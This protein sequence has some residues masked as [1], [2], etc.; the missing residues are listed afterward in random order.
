MVDDFGVDH[1]YA[2]RIDA[3]LTNWS[4][5]DV[6]APGVI[7]W[8]TDG[9][10]IT[11]EGAALAPAGPMLVE[12]RSE[13]VVVVTQTCDLRRSCWRPD[14]KGRPFVQISPLVR[15]AGQEL[16]IARGGFH[17]RFAPVPGAGDDAFADLERCTTIEKGVLVK[18]PNRLVGCRDDAERQ[19]FSR[20]VARQR[21]RYAFPDCVDRAVN[22]LRY[23]LRDKRD[24]DSPTGRAVRAVSSIRASAS[25]QFDEEEPFDLTLVFLIDPLQLPNATDDASEISAEHA[26]W[27]DQNPSP[28]LDQ[29]SA[30]LEQIGEPSDRF[31]VWQRIASAWVDKCEP[32]GAI[33][34]VS[35]EA[36]GLLAY[37]LG[38]AMR[39]PNL[40]LDHLTSEE[41]RIAAGDVFDPS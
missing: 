15:L 37:P 19:A 32:V 23:Y 3:E 8:M 20:A 28:S 30:R 9:Q 22:K 7:S 21:G 40:D 26:S 33:R 10:P 11:P 36:E 14:G 1:D 24:K 13:H 34:T 16:M 2:A 29:L 18:S 12:T 27:I 41:E 35:G 25:P 38:R 5:G 6:A 4:Q 17:P 31:D 39:E